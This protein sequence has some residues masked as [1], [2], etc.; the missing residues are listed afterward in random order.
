METSTT[1]SAWIPVCI[2][3]VNTRITLQIR[4]FSSVQ[5]SLQCLLSKVQVNVCCF[6]NLDSLLTYRIEL[7]LLIALSPIFQILQQ[8][9]VY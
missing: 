6:V 1:T 5:I 8:G 3:I 7:A 4:V 2:T 9:H